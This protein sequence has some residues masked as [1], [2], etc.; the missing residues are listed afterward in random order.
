MNNIKRNWFVIKCGNK[1]IKIN[2]NKIENNKNTN[3]K[4]IVEILLIIINL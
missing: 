3:I 2:L 4:K 1:R